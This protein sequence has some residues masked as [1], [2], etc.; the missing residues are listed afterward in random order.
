MNKILR[1]R[2]ASILAILIVAI[3]TGIIFLVL[4][5]LE[6]IGRLLNLNRYVIS[7]F[8][9]LDSC[10]L[11]LPLGIIVCSIILFF[12]LI[13][14]KER[15]N[16]IVYV[17]IIILLIIVSFSSIVLLS[18]FDEIFVFEYIQKVLSLLN[19]K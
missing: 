13:L 14:F 16:K 1:P 8:E 5:N 11:S 4:S 15:I 2:R 7:F 19:K 9:R 12:A 3:I 17:F 10:K 18:S 6:M